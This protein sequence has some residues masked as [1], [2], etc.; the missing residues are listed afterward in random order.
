MP[1]GGKNCTALYGE[2]F[3][4]GLAALESISHGKCIY[5]GR[6]LPSRESFLWQ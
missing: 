6:T 1:P 2:S 5:K 3:D 4:T